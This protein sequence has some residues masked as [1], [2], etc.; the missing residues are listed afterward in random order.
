MSTFKEKKVFV[1]AIKDG[2]TQQAAAIRAFPELVSNPE[3]A[4]TKASRMMRQKKVRRMLED[5]SE[6]AVSRIAELSKKARNEKV[7]LDANR[8]LLDRAGFK[9]V[10]KVQTQSLH[11]EARVD[12]SDPRAKAL[13][14]KYEAELLKTF[15]D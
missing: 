6:G 2:Y 7:K 9:A 13:K 15:N 1:N 3:Y 12:L 10:D 4:S 14:E 11:V 5:E 8:D